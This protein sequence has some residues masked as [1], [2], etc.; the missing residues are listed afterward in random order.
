MGRVIYNLTEWATAPAK[1][2]FGSQTVRLDGY[3]RQPVHTVEVLGL[4][5]QRI[6]LLVVSPHTDEHDAHTVMMTAAGPNNALT[7]ASLMISGQKVDAHE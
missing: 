7:V 3:R 1:L 6:T 2:A 4:N 5:R